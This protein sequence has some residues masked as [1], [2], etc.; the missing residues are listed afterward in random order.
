MLSI[1]SSLNF[2][3]LFIISSP[4]RFGQTVFLKPCSR[5]VLFHFQ[6]LNDFLFSYPDNSGHI[7]DLARFQLIITVTK[8]HRRSK[9]SAKDVRLGVFDASRPFLS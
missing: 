1:I 9:N 3:M 2:I 5:G 4:F 7:N 6:K 8:M